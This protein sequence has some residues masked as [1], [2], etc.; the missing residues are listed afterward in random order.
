MFGSSTR[1]QV[2]RGLSGSG[3]LSHVYIQQPPLRCSIPETHGL[4]YDD[5]NKLLLSPTSD[6]VLS[7]KI[8]PCTKFEP[9][10]S[11]SVSE[12]PVLSIRYSL[13]KKVICI[14]RSDQEFQFKNRETGESFTWRCKPESKSIL[15]FFWTDCPSC[16][17]IFIKTRRQVGSIVCLIPVLETDGPLPRCDAEQHSLVDSK[18]VLA[19]IRAIRR[20]LSL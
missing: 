20:L 17:I 5:G 10:N 1:D 2:P 6:Q 13:D 9:P 4:F 18:I 12:G 14:Q 16:D 8:V 19:F 15:G 11:D 3:A 7:W